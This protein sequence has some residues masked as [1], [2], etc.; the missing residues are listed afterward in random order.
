MFSIKCHNE[1]QPHSTL[2]VKVLILKTQL[3]Q[4]NTAAMLR[5]TC[6]VWPLQHRDCGF[7]F[8]SRHAIVFH[9]SLSYVLTALRCNGPQHRVSSKCVEIQSFRTNSGSKE[10]KRIISNGGETYFY[11]HHSHESIRRD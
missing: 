3:T 10:G 7:K 2:Y 4:P 8:S 11:G 1:F 6:S 9:L 5:V